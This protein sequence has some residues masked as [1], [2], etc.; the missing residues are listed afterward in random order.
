MEREE[1]WNVFQE[2][3]DPLGYLLY[4]AETRQGRDRGRREQTRTSPPR[5]RP[6]EETPPPDV[7][8]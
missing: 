5:R 1:L 2:T 7:R 6:G 3:G 8:M 4:R